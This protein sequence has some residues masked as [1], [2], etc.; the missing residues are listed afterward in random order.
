MKTIVR[1]VD[2]FVFFF[3]SSV[4]KFL[5]GRFPK[6]GFS[7][8]R[9]APPISAQAQSF[10]SL[11]RTCFHF[12]KEDFYFLDRFKRIDRDQC[13]LFFSGRSFVGKSFQLCIEFIIFV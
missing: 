11:R 8:F 6:K 1:A 13:N 7:R 10:D 5:S 2:F 9:L 4:P 3:H 12:L